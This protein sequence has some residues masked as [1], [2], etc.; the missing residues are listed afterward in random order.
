M[1]IER[2]GGHLSA[3]SDG[4]HGALFQ[5]V[6]PSRMNNQTAASQQLKN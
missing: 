1:I 4:T 5:F 2:H 6:L 3:S